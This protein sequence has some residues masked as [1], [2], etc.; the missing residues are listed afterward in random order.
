MALPHDALGWSVVV[1]FP[2]HTH[3]FW[4][5]RTPH[6]ESGQSQGD[7]LDLV[8]SKYSSDLAELFKNL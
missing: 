4:E 5:S 8:A 1:V 6:C 2:D 7:V 3:L